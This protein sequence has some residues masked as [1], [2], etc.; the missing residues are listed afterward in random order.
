M[1]PRAISGSGRENLSEQVE[2][3]NSAETPFAREAARKN[4]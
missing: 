2:V 4:G 3:T 1:S